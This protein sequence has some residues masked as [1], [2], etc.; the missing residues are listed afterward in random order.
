MRYFSRTYFYEDNCMGV[1]W[2]LF[3]K[4]FERVD[5]P[6]YYQ[7]EQS[8]VHTT[9]IDRL[10]HRMKSMDKLLYDSKSYGF[11]HQ[12]QEELEFRYVEL[13]FVNTLYSYLLGVKPL[14][15]DFLKEL[16]EGCILQ[17]PNFSKNKYYQERIHRNK[18]KQ[19]Q[20]LQKNHGLFLW[21][22]KTLTQYRKLR[23]KFH[24]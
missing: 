6:F 19:I 12:F 23:K 13:Y 2:L 3:C 16:L 10:R 15:R 4:H 17:V 21:Y 14:R 8:T 9:T 22:F 5:K 24:I 7:H 11:Y 1:L 20:M 18:R